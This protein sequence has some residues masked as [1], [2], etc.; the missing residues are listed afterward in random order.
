MRDGVILLFYDLCTENKDYRCEYRNFVK[1]LKSEGYMPL[2]ESVFFKYIRNV[3]MAKFGLDR[4]G[5]IPITQGNVF[6]LVLS[7][8]TFKKM[9][10]LRGSIPDFDSIKSPY[11]YL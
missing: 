9:V 2:Q 4:I 5:D 3:S 8:E 7:Y 10:V 11:I 6:C 1:Y